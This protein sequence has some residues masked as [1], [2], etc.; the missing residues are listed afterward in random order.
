M[1][2][3]ISILIYFAPLTHRT[4]RNPSGHPPNL[5]NP[6]TTSNPTDSA[7]PPSRSIRRGREPYPRP[8]RETSSSLIWRQ[9]RFWARKRR[10]PRRARKEQV[11]PF[12]RIGL[13]SRS[14]RDMHKLNPLPHYDRISLFRSFAHSLAFSLSNEQSSPPSPYPCTLPP[15]TGPQRASPPRSVSTPSPHTSGPGRTLTTSPREKP[16]GLGWERWKRS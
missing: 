3:S 8:S 10:L 14:S 2:C 4:I 5:L 12:G 7:S 15:H 16:M 13:F 11:S 9:G 1:L 6:S